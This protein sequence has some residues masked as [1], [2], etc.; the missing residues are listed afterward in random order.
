MPERVKDEREDVLI[1]D[2]AYVKV[3]EDIK[4]WWM[5]LLPQKTFGCMAE[6]MI[7]A[8]EEIKENKVGSVDLDFVEKIKKI[9][10]KHGFGHAEL[11]SFNK[12]I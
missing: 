10:D 5:S 3:P 4:F 7:L 11:T 2:G 1:V 8:I 6:T 12:K 9:G